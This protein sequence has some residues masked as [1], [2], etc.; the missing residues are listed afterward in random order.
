MDMALRMEANA[1][2]DS[3]TAEGEHFD[4]RQA[5]RLIEI[6]PVFRSPPLLSFGFKMSRRNVGRREGYAAGVGKVDVPEEE[7]KNIEWSSDGSP[8]WRAGAYK[9]THEP[10]LIEI[11]QLFTDTMEDDGT[12][13][14]A[15]L[16]Y[17]KATGAPQELKLYV[18]H[19]FR[20]GR[21][22][23]IIGRWR[24]WKHPG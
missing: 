12:G 18:P 6:V 4:A 22:T 17:S 10:G 14:R 5:R 21:A 7:H 20:I 19:I 15:Q 3:L 13:R 8:I 24:G 9:L 1:L 2:V 11:D 16:I 23:I